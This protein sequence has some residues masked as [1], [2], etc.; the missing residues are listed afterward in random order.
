M[1]SPQWVAVCVR[2]S[3][4]M[5]PSDTSQ[6]ICQWECVFSRLDLD[7]SSACL[8]RFSDRLDHRDVAASG[9]NDG[10]AEWQIFLLAADFGIVGNLAN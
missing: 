6:T 4:F 8:E 1:G 9:P 2:D 10:H 7:G 3:A 5:P